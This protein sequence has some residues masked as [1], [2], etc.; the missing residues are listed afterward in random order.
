MTDV[1]PGH[2]EL[3]GLTKRFG[4]KLA[5][6]HASFVIEPGKVT[7]LLGPNGAGKSTLMQLMMGLTSGEGTA[8][9]GGRAYAELDRPGRTV[10]A[11][12]DPNCMHPKRSARNHLLMLAAGIGVGRERVEDVLRIVGLQDVATKKAGEFSLGMRQR[13]GLASALL[14][15]PEFLMLDEPANGLDPQGVAWLRQFLRTFAAS[16]R[17]VLVSSHL[18]A[19]MQMLVD[20]VVVIARGRIVADEPMGAFLTRHSSDQVRVR[21]ADRAALAEALRAAGYTV[22][23]ADDLLRVTADDPAAVGW[24]AFAAGIAVAELYREDASLEAVF[25]ELT[26]GEDEY[27]GSQVA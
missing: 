27:A 10:G 4:D 13:L 24:A 25:L 2:V 8:R 3:H 5:L 11:M 26:S 14:G 15:D 18:L 16:G 1:R 19:E 17:S 9:F 12:L 7:G 20:H 23:D 21:A 6:D 22:D